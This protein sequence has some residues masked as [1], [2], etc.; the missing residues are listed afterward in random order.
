MPQ[1]RTRVGGSSARWRQQAQCQQGLAAHRAMEGSDQQE[2]AMQHI[3][4]DLEAQVAAIGST[5]DEER[6][7]E[8]FLV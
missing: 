2:A 1:A 6:L 4:Q 8:E 7:V 5:W 3:V